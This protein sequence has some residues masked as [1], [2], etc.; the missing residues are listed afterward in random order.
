MLRCMAEDLHHG[1]TLHLCAWRCA[2]HI[3]TMMDLLWKVAIACCTEEE[4][5]KDR[6]SFDGANTFHKT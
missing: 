6:T 4:L 3:F 1:V 2:K 5:S